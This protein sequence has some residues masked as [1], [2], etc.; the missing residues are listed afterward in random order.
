M[1]VYYIQQLIDGPAAMV[2]KYQDKA[3]FGD[4]AQALAAIA[5]QY[6]QAELLFEEAGFGPLID[7]TRTYVAW[8]YPVRP[9]DADPRCMARLVFT[10][11]RYVEW[12][13]VRGTVTLHCD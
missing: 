2:S 12:R 7:N 8:K 5:T 3:P 9:S 10:N 11:G 6:R 4:E 13:I 1:N